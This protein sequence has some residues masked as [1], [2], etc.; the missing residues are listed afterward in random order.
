MRQNAKPR[1]K[2]Q[3]N[4]KVNPYSNYAAVMIKCCLFISSE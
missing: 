1:Q 4:L 2:L 3:K